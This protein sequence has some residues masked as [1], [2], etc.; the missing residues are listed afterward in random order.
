MNYKIFLL[1]FLTT[2]SNIFSDTECPYIVDT[3]DRRKD[4][5]STVYKIMQYNV[6]WLFIDYCVSSDC[7]GA[8][9]D[10][11][12]I[13]EANTHMKY[14]TDVINKINPDIVNIC[15]VEGCD[16]LNILISGLYN[17]QYKPYLIKGTD[18]STGQ[19][20]GLITKVDP[21]SNLYR[22]DNRLEYPINGSKCGYNG[23]SSTTVSKHYISEFLL[24]NVK[25]VIIG[26]HLIAIP[27]DPQRCAQ[28]EAQT[29]I[30]Q[31]I[32]YNYYKNGY[33]I[34]MI[35]DFNDYDAQIS[36]INNNKPISQALNILKGLYGTYKGKYQLFSVSKFIDKNTR[37][38][39]WYDMDAN[40]ITTTNDF[41]MIDHILLTPFLQNKLLDAYIYQ[42][43]DEYCG[44]Y[45]SDHYPIIIELNL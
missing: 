40:C 18:T 8:G 12:N 1:Y 30:L 5:S 36:D 27:T 6:Q 20:I 19:N 38:T 11:K 22:T 10:W 2:I 34:I 21:I 15:E 43:Y 39:N 33:E 17:N 41:A 26:A 25:I 44:K 4:N 32:I 13:T 7:P 35:G 9:C 42:E 14:V 16:E 29:L 24:N 31:E 23:T 3:K 28:R 37:F 45:D